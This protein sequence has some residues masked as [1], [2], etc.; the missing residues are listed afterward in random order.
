[1]AR[2]FSGLRTA[3]V[4]GLQLPVATT[5]RARLLGLAHLDREAAG[6]GLLLPGCR[7]VHTF[8]MRF[9]IDVVFLDAGCGV[10]ERHDAVGPRRILICRGAHAVAELPAEA[11]GEGRRPAP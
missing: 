5:R 8:G 3:S 6:P 1:M 10:L 11:G 4:L 9:F 7:S 2:R